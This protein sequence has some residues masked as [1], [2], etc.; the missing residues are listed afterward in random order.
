MHIRLNK[1][2]DKK[3]DDKNK[4]ADDK[5][6]KADDKYKKADDKDKKAD[7]ELKLKLIVTKK[8]INHIILLYEKYG[9]IGAFGKKEIEES[10]GLKST[11]AS[12]ILRI[13]LD[14][15]IIE[16]VNGYGKGKYKFKSG[17]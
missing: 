8:S 16:S 15:N 2:I 3:A 14:V 7:L 9:K 17:L 10:T 5:N 13:M 6:K 1:E 11:R 12:E 4:K